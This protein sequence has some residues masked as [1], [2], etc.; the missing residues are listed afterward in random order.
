VRVPPAP[1]EDPEKLA[2]HVVD[3][4]RAARSGLLP[5]DPASLWIAM[6][7]DRVF[8]IPALRLLERQAR[9]APV[10][11]YLFDW[12]SP[13][14]GGILGACHGIELPFVFGTLRDPRAAQLVGSGADA[15]RLAH[16]MQDAWL[17]FA[18]RGD[19]GWPAYDAA[20]RATQR[21]GREPGTERDPMAA[22]RRLWEGWL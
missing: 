15:E 9:H 5:I 6:Q 13:A 12:A 17:A 16:R 2:R 14:F 4:Y 22:E 19:P 20:D 11:A 18:R 7:T 21:L 10:F 8:R 1:S 3:T